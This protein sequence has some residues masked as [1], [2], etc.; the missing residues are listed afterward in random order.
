MN[1]R[2]TSAYKR[3]QESDMDSLW[4]AYAHASKDKWEAWDDCRKTCF[5]LGGRDLKVIGANTY[6]FS[7]GF[8]FEKD[9]VQKFC[10][11]TKSGKEIAEVE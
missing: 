5:A 4:K 9:G 11:I 6:V 8:V 1:K 7:A 3:W 10:Y 2:L